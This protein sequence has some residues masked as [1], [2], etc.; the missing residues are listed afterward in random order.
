M[1]SLIQNQPRAPTSVNTALNTNC[2][3]ENLQKHLM[4]EKAAAARKM[5]GNRHLVDLSQACQ[6]V[7]H[8]AT[9][10]V[11]A[12]AKNLLQRVVSDVLQ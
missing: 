7:I 11:R 1:G 8:A 5:L 3:T 2:S 4:Y 10:G 6:A 12:Q 9:G